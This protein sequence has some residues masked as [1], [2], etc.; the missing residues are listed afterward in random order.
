M[1]D[2]YIVT[3]GVGSSKNIIGAAFAKRYAI[4]LL[5]GESFY[6]D[7][8]FAQA[9]AGTPFDTVESSAWAQRMAV[10]LAASGSCVVVCK[11]LD[12]AELPILK[13]CGTVHVI[14]TDP[15]LEET[16]SRIAAEQNIPHVMYAGITPNFAKP[17]TVVADIIRL[18]HLLNPELRAAA[19][20]AGEEAAYK[21]WLD[22]YGKRH[23]AEIL[24]QAQSRTW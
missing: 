10:S 17:E 12:G 1:A 3:G 19:E 13:T 6:N 2:F 22:Y 8:Q 16:H 15:S 18:E 11:H 14:H 4:P 9:C 24:A 5:F 21:S 20:K 7:E 23:H